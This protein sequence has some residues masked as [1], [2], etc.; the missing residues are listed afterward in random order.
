[1]ALQVPN[2]ARTVP[3][4]L[5][6]ASPWIPRSLWKLWTLTALLISGLVAVGAMV[7]YTPTFRPE[8]APVELAGIQYVL[9]TPAM[10]FAA[11]LT[12][13]TGEHV[14]DTWAPA[15]SE[16]M[17]RSTDEVGTTS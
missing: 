8:L 11:A 6:A 7:L 13:G 9:D 4:E 10:L 15:G 5:C 3:A 16:A 17:A 12:L 14:T 2:A 1:M